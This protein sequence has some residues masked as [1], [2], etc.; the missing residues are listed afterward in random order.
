MEDEIFKFTQMSDLSS[1][2]SSFVIIMSHGSEEHIDGGRGQSVVWGTD[3]QYLK[4]KDILEQFTAINCPH[5]NKK[6]KIFIFQ[7][8]R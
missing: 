2:A 3:G 7:S 1:V 6:P 4:V 8:C 5:M